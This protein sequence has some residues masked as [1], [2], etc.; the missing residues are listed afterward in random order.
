MN[1]L[2]FNIEIN[3]NKLIINMEN[4]LLSNHIDHLV[5]NKFNGQIILSKEIKTLEIDPT[6][7][8]PSTVKCIRKLNGFN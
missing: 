2:T 1:N 5:I 6:K 7:I 8:M 4:L 3:K